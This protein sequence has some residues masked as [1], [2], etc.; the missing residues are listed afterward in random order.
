MAKRRQ[1][2]NDILTDILKTL[3]EQK[4]L[5]ET[6]KQITGEVEKQ[7]K[8][9]KEQN[10]ELKKLKKSIKELQETSESFRQ[11]IENSGKIA[12]S[13]FATSKDELNELNEKLE[14]SR[15][16]ISE[17][18]DKLGSIGGN[19]FTGLFQDFDKF[20]DDILKVK[21]Q[22]DELTKPTGN[23]I[24]DAENNKKAEELLDI[25]NKLI[26]ESKGYYSDA[27]KAQEKYNKRLEEG[28][29]CLDDFEERLS[30][31]TKAVRKGFNEISD[32]INQ[33][34]KNAEELFAPFN[35]AQDAALAYAK[36]MGMSRKAATEYLN[37]TL[38]WADDNNIGLLFNKTT[39]ELIAMQAKFS[40]A[41]GRNIQ[42][43]NEQKKDMLAIENILGEDTMMSIANNLEN[44]GLGMSDSADFVHKTMSEA[45]KFG[46]SA[47]KL[48]K[49]VNENIK[50]AQNYTF[51]NG[52]DGL[53]SM[54]KKAMQLKTDLSL[55]NGFLEKTSTVE[56]AIA[57]GA[58]LQVLGGSYAMGSDPLSM[59]YE[60][61]SDAEG[62]FD[63]AVNMAKGKVFYNEKTK[64]FEMGAM[65]R[66][67]MK[68]AATVMGVDPSKLID[69]AFRQASLGRIEEQIKDSQIANDPEMVNLVKNVATWD[70]G[71]AVVQ[72]G[73]ETKNVRDLTEEDKER[74]SAMQ[75]TEEQS[76]QEMVILMRSNNE[77][78]SGTTKESLN[79]QAESM[80][81][82]GEDIGEMLLN[83]TNM[84]NL[85]SRLTTVVSIA[86]TV[87][88]MASGIWNIAKGTARVIK[89]LPAKI[90]SVEQAIYRTGMKGAGGAVGGV[91]D[92]A[93]T[94]GGFGN[95]MLGRGKYSN[96][97]GLRGSAI[98]GMAAGGLSMGYSILSGEMETNPHTAQA[99]AGLASAGAA[100]GG[101]FGPIGM[102]AGG[103]IGGIT[104]HLIGRSKDKEEKRKKEEEERRVKERNDIINEFKNDN[105]DLANIFTNEGLQGD[106]TTEELKEI[107]KA[108]ENYRIDRGE[109]SNS[110]VKKIKE[111]GDFDIIK[112][113]GVSVE[114]PYAKGGPVT[115][116]THENGGSILHSYIDKTTGLQYDETVEKGE[117]ILP[118]SVMKDPINKAV[119]YNMWKRGTITPVT[120]WGKETKIINNNYNT[121]NNSGKI[122]AD[123]FSM[124]VGGTIKLESSNGQSI[125]ISDTLLKNPSFMRQL[126]EIIAKN[127]NVIKN[128][129]FNKETY[130]QKFS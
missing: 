73:N 55:V 118:A 120:P 8:G 66:Y 78:L 103:V 88:G 122:S 10:D 128:K 77:I 108:I 35:K 47:T 54:A 93:N 13:A 90:T 109:L 97:R 38:E 124:N 94:A 58:N 25:L 27:D 51:K 60:S 30:V 127:T 119:V 123:P 110:L 52:L 112:R 113:N 69:V 85:I 6:Q 29:T 74:L 48:T 126:T 91:G 99:R 37:N 71:N 4:E 1:N 96:L 75:L 64:N 67:M 98:G 20:A 5:L 81:E 104:G 56:G 72:I 53:T 26:K 129:A 70:N 65:D 14:K 40:D 45:A 101:L 18:A 22:I 89:G 57:T 7:N 36:N 121:Q 9:V 11:I 34:K 76:L 28:I 15:T 12:R 114:I 92:A 115:G 100:I 2:T 107:K 62:L 106:Y 42:L 63:R 32:G 111:N 116:P 102:I 87:M 17:Y 16:T 49:I 33:I 82:I 79:D 117:F 59:M 84:L 61:L 31:R 41:I 80:K 46:V 44:F 24:L 50:M 83:S 86:S 130:A 21:E 125:D 68:Q 39:D 19:N 95:F 23:E 105:A 43:T 3:N